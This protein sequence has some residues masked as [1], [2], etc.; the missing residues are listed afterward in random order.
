MPLSIG[1]SEAVQLKITA[2]NDIS[3]KFTIE[4]KRSAFKDIPNYTSVSQTWMPISR[5]GETFKKYP[6]WAP[7]QINYNNVWEE[8]PGTNYF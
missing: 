1:R 4:L 2:L 6:C 7:F 8:S 3:R 5:S